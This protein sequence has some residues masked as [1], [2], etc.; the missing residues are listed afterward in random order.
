MTTAAEFIAGFEGYAGRAYWDVNAWRL[1]YGSDTEGPEKNPVT[2]GMTTTK[3]RALQN[4]A[5]RIPEFAHEAVYGKTGMGADTWLG[6]TENQKTAVID[7]VYNYGELRFIVYPND[8]EKTAAGIKARQNDNGGVNRKRRLAEAALYLTDAAPTAHT[9]P[10]VPAPRPP[11][12]YAP[13]PV[14][15]PPA[16]HATPPSIPASWAAR[17]AIEL[18]Q[19]I[20]L[21]TAYRA[22]FPTPF[23]EAITSLQKLGTAPPPPLQ[24]P[25]AKP[26][27]QPQ[28][29]PIMN[30]QV[31]A[32]FR[33]IMLALG[34]AAVSKGVVDESTMTSLVG[35]VIA[36]ASFGWSL[37]GHS[38]NSI[39]AAAA[40]LPEVQKV[41]TTSAIADSP[42]FAGNNR[43]VT[44]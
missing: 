27:A 28:G 22:E 24:I 41:V 33:S 40:S 35:G 34:G 2:K 39:I 11:A 9:A 36:A 32:T 29:T 30:P 14:P 6:L 20:A 3:E 26:A 44:R 8:A 10:P 31:L 13:P 19:L 4:L 23:D 43:V 25:A 37:W 12:P 15:M 42:K 5:L 1:G 16:P 18:D 17:L 21:Q 7:F 38:T